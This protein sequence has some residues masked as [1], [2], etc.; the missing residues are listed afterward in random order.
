MCRMDDPDY[1]PEVN[2]LS[3]NTLRLTVVTYTYLSDR[4]KEY[5]TQM[6]YNTVCFFA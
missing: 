6:W 2:W 1:Q 5:H 3:T 4:D